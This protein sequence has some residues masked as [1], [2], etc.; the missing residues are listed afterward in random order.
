MVGDTLVCYGCENVGL[1]KN[2][3]NAQNDENGENHRSAGSTEPKHAVGSYF[4][5]FDVYALELSIRIPNFILKISGYYQRIYLP[6]IRP[7]TR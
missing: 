7:I 1:E 2:A 3:Q 4:R 5:K 6:T